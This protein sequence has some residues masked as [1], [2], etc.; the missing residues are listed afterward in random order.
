M[1]GSR[2]RNPPGWK[3]LRG[4]LSAR[5][6][7]RLRNPHASLRREILLLNYTLNH[8]VLSNPRQAGGKDPGLDTPVPDILP[9]EAGGW[10]AQS[11]R[12]E[13]SP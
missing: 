5:A 7:S 11:S 3:F 4:S 1:V 9:T 10:P 13:V 2:I 8:P 12:E 6:M